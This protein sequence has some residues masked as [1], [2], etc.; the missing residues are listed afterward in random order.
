MKVTPDGRHRSV[1][2]PGAISQVEVGLRIELTAFSK[3][4]PLTPK[5]AGAEPVNDSDDLSKR[6]VLENA[7]EYRVD[8]CPTSE[9]I[10]GLAGSNSIGADNR[11]VSGSQ[12]SAD[13]VGIADYVEPVRNDRTCAGLATKAIG[14]RIDLEATDVAYSALMPSQ[15]M[16][17]EPVGVHQRYSADAVLGKNA[18][19]NGADR[20]NAG[21]DCMGGS[22]FRPRPETV[23]DSE[24]IK[25]RIKR[26]ELRRSYLH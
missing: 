6:A 23:Q 16:G 17:L 22:R 2:G 8:A 4:R 20:A 12:D 7:R 25:P 13:K 21:D 1:G 5:T 9:V 3:R 10:A 15:V 14:D 26:N 24:R 11:N 18:R 19:G